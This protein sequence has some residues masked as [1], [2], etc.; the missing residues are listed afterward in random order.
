MRSLTQVRIGKKLLAVAAV[1]VDMERREGEPSCFLEIA[2]HESE[3]MDE[4]E[5]TG[6]SPDELMD[7]LGRLKHIFGEMLALYVAL[8]EVVRLPKVPAW[9]KLTI[10]HDYLGVSAWTCA[11]APQGSF[12]ILPGFSDAAERAKTWRPPKDKTVKKVVQ[13]CWQ[14]AT[15]NN[16]FLEFRHQPGHRSEDAG[17]NHFVRFNRR[18]D[19]LALEAA[20]LSKHPVI[21]LGRPY[22]AV[23]RGNP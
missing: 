11:A 9:P 2:L 21:S 23:T 8:Q 15:E 18:A 1:I 5:V 17:V 20:K 13:A 3:L 12:E 16:L 22:S 14:V 6:V 4:G 7:A 10:V 19:K